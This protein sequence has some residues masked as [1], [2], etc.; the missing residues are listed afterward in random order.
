MYE[1]QLQSFLEHPLSEIEYV[2]DFYNIIEKKAKQTIFPY[3][4]PQHKFLT[5]S[6]LYRWLLTSLS[7]KELLE[8]DEDAI[9]TLIKNNSLPYIYKQKMLY[10]AVC[11]KKNI[12]LE[13]LALDFLNKSKNVDSIIFWTTNT[14]HLDSVLEIIHD[15]YL[16]NKTKSLISES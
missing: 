4:K 16:L 9:N 3:L 7:I 6:P 15:S 13:K 5:Y 12:S 1:K 10:E 14:Q 8:K 11:K 2:Q